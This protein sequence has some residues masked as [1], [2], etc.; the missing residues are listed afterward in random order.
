MQVI[1]HTGAHSTDDE[2]LLRCLLRN[3]ETL[4]G[5]GVAVPGPS[6][7]RTLL[8]TTFQAMESAAPSPDAR[9]V[10][11]DAILDDEVADRVILSNEHFFGSPRYAIGNGSLYPEGPERIS[12]LRELFQFDQVEMFMAIRNPATFLPAVMQK[13]APK[14][15]SRVIA[16]LDLQNLRWSDTL[17]RIRDEAPDVSITVWC[18]ED[19][20]LI[21]GQVVRDLAGLEPG[22][23]LEGNFDLLTEIMSEEGM[24]RF[25]VYLRENPSL[26]EMQL[27]RVIAAFLDKFAIDEE[28]EEEL[29]LPGWT[30]D[31]VEEMTEIYDDDLFRIQRIPGVQ[32]ITP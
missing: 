4:S 9:D 15:K 13:A 12:R 18:N 8:K 26:S 25:Q 3:K 10:L 1:V 28:L 6:N 32:M 24:K 20:P 2:R 21:W 27:R 11:L 31:L 30:E 23:D 22:I 14:R 7:Y 5:S 29:D 17:L 19:L 16:S